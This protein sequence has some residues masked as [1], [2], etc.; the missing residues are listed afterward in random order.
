MRLHNT[1]R[2]AIKRRQ[3]I[4]DQLFSADFCLCLGNQ[5]PKNTPFSLLESDKQWFMQDQN[6]ACRWTCARPSRNLASTCGNGKCRVDAHEIHTCLYNMTLR[7]CSNHRFETGTVPEP[8]QSPV[9]R[10]VPLC[11]VVPE[12]ADHLAM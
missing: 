11:P 1:R 10:P 8:F 12:R 4:N 7:P 9:F 3:Y 2:R 6:V 5:I